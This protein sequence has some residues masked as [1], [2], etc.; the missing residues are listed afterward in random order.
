M[1]WNS[2][3]RTANHR[4]LAPPPYSHLTGPGKKRLPERPHRSTAVS[5][6]PRCSLGRQ[7]GMVVWGPQDRDERNSNGGRTSLELDVSSGG[8]VSRGQPAAPCDPGLRR[9]AWVRPI[10]VAGHKAC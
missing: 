3:S 10:W 2:L 4:T 7:V 5:P 1:A 8:R 6:G 9:G